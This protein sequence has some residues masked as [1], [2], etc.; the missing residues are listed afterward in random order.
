MN[1]GIQYNH[2]MIHPR[3]F[4]DFDSAMEAAIEPRNRSGDITLP[5]PDAVHFQRERARAAYGAIAVQEGN[6]VAPNASGNLHEQVQ[7][8]VEE[9][10][11]LHQSLLQVSAVLEMK[12]NFRFCSMLFA[13]QSSRC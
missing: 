5:S 13:L 11:T 4:H 7:H 8:A 9:V 6:Q 3:Y 10:A 2:M 12:L 1:I